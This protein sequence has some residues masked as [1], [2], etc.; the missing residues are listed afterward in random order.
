MQDNSEMREKAIEER[1]RQEVAKIGG[2]AYKLVS[3]GNA[4]MPDRLVC[5]P[6][7]KAV[8]VELKRP[9]GGKVSLLQKYRMSEL[10]IR[11]FEVRVINTEEQID[12][13]INEFN[14]I[15]TIK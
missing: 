13:F 11:G 14:P 5:L 10:R 8:F 3:T 15:G 9:K 6:G 4:G 2:K 1:L 7:G 12:E